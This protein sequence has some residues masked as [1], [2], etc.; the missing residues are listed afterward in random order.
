[1]DNK[2]FRYLMDKHNISTS[3]IAN[4]L[5]LSISQTNYKLKKGRFGLNDIK[6]LLELFN[7]SFEELF[8]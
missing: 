4:L 2:F 1:M 5:N 8:K 6:K 3:D 7:L